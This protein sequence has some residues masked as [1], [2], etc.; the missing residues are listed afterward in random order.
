MYN[1]L[2]YGLLLGHHSEDGEE[3]FPTVKLFLQ[4]LLSGLIITPPRHAGRL[5]QLVKNIQYPSPVA[6]SENCF[7]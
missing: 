5:S 4:N 3:A 7:G 2:V 6:T 1:W